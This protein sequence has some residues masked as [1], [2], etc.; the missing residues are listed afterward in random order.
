MKKKESCSINSAFVGGIDYGTTTAVG[1]PIT[2]ESDLSFSFDAA[3]L[4]SSG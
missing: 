3:Y 4:C 2:I 1:N